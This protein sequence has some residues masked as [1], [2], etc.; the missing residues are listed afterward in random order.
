MFC[1]ARLFDGLA[2]QGGGGGEGGVCLQFCEL[3]AQE[4][5]LGGEV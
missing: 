4:D 1:L 5:M 3:G 2:L